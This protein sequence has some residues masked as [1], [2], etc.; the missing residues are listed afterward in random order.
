MIFIGLSKLTL[1]QQQTAFQPIQ[2]SV[3]PAISPCHSRHSSGSFTPPLATECQNVAAVAKNPSQCHI[4]SLIS[5]CSQP[6][7]VNLPSKHYSMDMQVP[8]TTGVINT[9][10]LQTTSTPKVSSPPSL[11]SKLGQPLFSFPNSL[12]MLPVSSALDSTHVR[13]NPDILVDTSQHTKNSMDERQ[14]S[15][16]TSLVFSSQETTPVPLIFTPSPT[17]INNFTTSS[18]DPVGKTSPV[19]NRTYLNGPASSLHTSPSQINGS[20]RDSPSVFPAPP[21]H[22]INKSPTSTPTRT[23][24]PCNTSR[25]TT[26]DKGFRST[27]GSWHNSEDF[28]SQEAIKVTSEA[29]EETIIKCSSILK[30]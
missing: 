5:A 10:T 19:L 17:G 13:S 9:L 12:N 23:H 18:N 14:L 4:E 26:P 15:A 30:V 29:L 27:D 22:V 24:S 20:G 28:D 8:E 21:L 11:P 16:N 2:P 25:S 1:E 6:S 7:V 3:S